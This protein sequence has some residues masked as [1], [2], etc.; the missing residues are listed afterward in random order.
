MNALQIAI[1]ERGVIAGQESRDSENCIKCRGCPLAHVHVD[2][3]RSVQAPDSMANTTGTQ[4]ERKEADS[5]HREQLGYD[6]PH[7]AALEDNPEHAEKLTW[8]VALSALFLGT[9]F[10]GPV[11]RDSHVNGTF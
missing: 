6:D 7:R 2:C 1:T 10:T 5:E 9:S 8:S 3:F 11:S 4:T